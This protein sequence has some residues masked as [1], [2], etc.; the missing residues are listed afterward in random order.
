MSI[1]HKLASAVLASAMAIF[2]ATPSGADTFSVFAAPPPDIFTPPLIVT[3]NGT[4]DVGG[5]VISN[6]AL[7]VNIYTIC[8]GETFSEMQG[9]QFLGFNA[10]EFEVGG[11]KDQNL[12]LQVVFK[13]LP[14][15]TLSTFTGGIVYGFAVLDASC[16]SCGF[17]LGYNIIPGITNGIPGSSITF[18]SATVPI[19]GAG[20]PGLILAG[21]GLLG[22]WRRRQ[23]IA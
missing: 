18:V 12:L 1:F 17:S 22:W 16:S 10:W 4:I 11:S 23:K 5:G 7:Q 2:A 9:T 14:G 6:P 20:L 8:C 3:L 21:G 13:P 19:V 15:E